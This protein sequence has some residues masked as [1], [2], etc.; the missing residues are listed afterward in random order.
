MALLL[1]KSNR[2]FLLYFF[3][4]L[5]SLSLSCLEISPKPLQQFTKAMHHMTTLDLSGVLPTDRYDGVLKAI[6]ENMP[7][8]KML[9][10]S[11]GRFQEGGVQASAIDLLLPT[12]QNPLRGCPNLVHLDIRD[13]TFVTVELLKKIILRLPKLRY[14]KHALLM[15]TL[16]EL[17]EKEISVD[18][19]RCL[20]CF[21]S[22]WSSYWRD[23]EMS[24]DALLRE[25][26]FTRFGN[27]TEVDIVVKDKSE[28]FW[29][30]ILMQLKKIQRLTLYNVWK[31]QEFLL[32]VLESNGGCLEYLSLEYLTGDLDLSDI[33]RTCPGLVELHVSCASDTQSH[34]PKAKTSKSDPV[35][36]CLR[37]LDLILTDEY[38]CS[39]ATLVSLLKSPCLEEIY[40]FN[41]EAMSDDA[42]FNFLSVLCA[43]YRR[44]SKL[45]TIF[46][47]CCPNITEEPFVCWLDIEDCMLEFLQLSFCK[48]VNSKGL[49]AAAERHPKP[50]SVYVN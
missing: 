4:K 24:Y 7:N 29:K 33:M 31:S 34:Q 10:I 27:I 23:N 11:L 1:F 9:D 12:R 39:K 47:E 38:I 45:K 36:T 30:E 18:M 17:T 37:K 26:V 22:D 5:K 6:S 13:N 43:G 2:V 41:V 50:L 42:M 25:P 35:L 3:Q 19:G 28:H 48:K 16:V 46:F 15:K 32:P 21:F 14:L 8:L 49:K 40:L 44:S 20:R